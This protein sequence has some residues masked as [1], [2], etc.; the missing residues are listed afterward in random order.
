MGKNRNKKN[1][2]IGNIIQNPNEHQYKELEKR[3][4][5]NVMSVTDEKEVSKLYLFP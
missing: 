5:I 2:K 3:N 1:K 4:N